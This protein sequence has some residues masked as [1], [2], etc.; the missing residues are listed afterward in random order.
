MKRITDVYQVTGVV[1]LEDTTIHLDSMD[2]KVEVESEY[3]EC[4]KSTGYGFICGG[5]WCEQWWDD[6]E[7]DALKEAKWLISHKMY[8][9]Y[10]DYDIGVKYIGS[11]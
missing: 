2:I 1:Y 6:T 3:H 11:V 10:V 8:R 5:Q 7:D 9:D 4:D